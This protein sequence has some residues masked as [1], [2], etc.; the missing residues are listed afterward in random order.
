[1]AITSFDENNGDIEIPKHTMQ[2][3]EEKAMVIKISF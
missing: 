1:M 3:N 2:M